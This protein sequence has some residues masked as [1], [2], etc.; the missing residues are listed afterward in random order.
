MLLIAGA[1]GDVILRRRRRDQGIRDPESRGGR[2]FLHIDRRPVPDIFRQGEEGEPIRASILDLRRRMRDV[3]RAL[4]RNER[5]TI[6]HRGREKGV[7]HP[8]GSRKAPGR[9]VSEHPAF[10]MWK[11]RVD[12]RNV[13]AA[14]SALR[15]TRHAL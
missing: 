3:L 8:S 5:V 9:R 12:L 14:I 1:Q 11:D 7:I 13:R 15:K 2:E 6:L 10:G 4:E